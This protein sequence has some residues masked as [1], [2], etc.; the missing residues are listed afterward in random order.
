[1][2][3]E[4]KISFIMNALKEGTY[5]TLPDTLTTGEGLV[6]KISLSGSLSEN[7]IERGFLYI[8]A[9]S[10]VKY[11]PHNNDLE[12]YRLLQGVLS[13]D[14][15][16]MEINI[17]GQNGEHGIDIVP[18]DTIIETCKMNELFLGESIDSYKEKYSYLKGR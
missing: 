8:P 11:H 13:I 7:G 17:C 14:N 2:T 12:V 18:T 3:K 1:M 5:T 9:G 4:E 10:G 6:Y 16:E 15:K